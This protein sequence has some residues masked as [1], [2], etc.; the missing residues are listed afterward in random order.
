VLTNDAL[1][2]SA[3]GVLGYSSSQRI[4]TMVTDVVHRTLETGLTE[5]RMSDGILAS[6]LDLRQFLFD[7]VYENPVATAEFQKASGVLGGLWERLHA[8]PEQY[9]DSTTVAE[10][11]IDAAARDFLAGMTDRYAVSLFE[12][13]FVPRSWSV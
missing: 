2:A 13:L 6:T 7:A 10:E 11:G 4:N 9:L 3:T 1:P 5:V 12:E 8:R